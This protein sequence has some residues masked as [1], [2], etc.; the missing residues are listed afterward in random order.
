MKDNQLLFIVVALV[1]L[2]GGFVL[3]QNMNPQSNDMVNQDTETNLVQQESESN[4]EQEQAQTNPNTIVD[5]ASANPDF[6]TLVTAINQAGLVEE[7]SAEGSIT[8]FAPTN[9][10]FAS[11]PEGALEALIADPVALTNVLTYHVI[12]NNVLST[13]I[14]NGD[15][16]KALNEKD[17]TFKVENGLVFVNSAKVLQPDIIASNGVIHVIDTVLLPTE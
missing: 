13:D 3:F 2:V 9:E 4:S 16:V 6:S 15:T 17:L 14:K 8:V 7:L 1:V 5:L 10:A 11:L 12:N